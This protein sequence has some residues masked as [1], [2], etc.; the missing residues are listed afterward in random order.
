MDHTRF[1]SNRSISG[2]KSFSTGKK[3][4]FSA[5]IS[6]FLLLSAEILLVLLGFSFSAPAVSND[7]GHSWSELEYEQDPKLPWSWIPVPGATGTAGSASYH[8]NNLGFRGTKAISQEKP[9]S[10]IRVVCMG[11][12]CSMG[13]EVDDSETYC[14]VLGKL[15]EK[16]LGVTVE[17][18]NAG[19]P[20]YTS[21]QGLHQLETRILKLQP[22]VITFSYCWNDHTFAIHMHE[23]LEILL[24]QKFLGLPD[25]D[26]PGVSFSSKLHSSISRLRSYQVMDFLLWKIKP[27]NETRPEDRSDVL[28]D[29]ESVPVR[30][31]V[32]DYKENLSR[33][34][35]LTRRH[36][37]IP[38]LMN[39]PSQPLR[40]MHAFQELANSLNYEAPTEKDWDQFCRLMRNLFVRRQA[41]YNDELREVAHTTFTG[42]VDMVSVFEAGNVEKLLI[43]PVHP[44]PKGHEIIATELSRTMVKL[45]NETRK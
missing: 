12:S 44:T 5:V 3:I 41:E 11:D 14:Y 9:D 7:S 2:Q 20:G 27:E 35:E 25:K 42:F 39:Q 36:N 18:I 24:H 30:V 6:S 32:A 17:A 33:M 13:W 43:D 26:L 37:A 45:L 10:T 22:D 1:G 19:V 29:I 16:A 23:T 21:F 31:D 8:F 15:L 38:V 34:I 40:S 28:V 4:L